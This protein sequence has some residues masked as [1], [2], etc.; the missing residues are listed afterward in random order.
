MCNC[1]LCKICQKS[2]AI[3]EGCHEH[4]IKDLKSSHNLG[5]D[6]LCSECENHVVAIWFERHG[7][8]LDLSTSI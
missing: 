3:K 1:K 7:I 5:N 6:D 2:V 8:S 4:H